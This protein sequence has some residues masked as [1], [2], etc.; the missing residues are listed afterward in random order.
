MDFDEVKEELAIAERMEFNDE[1]ENILGLLAK[2]LLKST[3]LQSFDEL[4]YCPKVK[5][6]IA[7]KF[8]FKNIC[9]FEQAC[10]I[11]VNIVPPNKRTQSIN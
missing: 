8:C 11:N 6:Y 1:I 9:Q 7:L 5:E 10:K 2:D 3:I 4:S